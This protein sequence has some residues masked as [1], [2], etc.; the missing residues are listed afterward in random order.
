MLL[1]IDCAGVFF[2]GAHRQ[3]TATRS[4]GAQHY[5]GPRLPETISNHGKG[6]FLSTRQFTWTLGLLHNGSFHVSALLGATNFLLEVCC[7]FD[8]VLQYRLTLSFQFLRRGISRF[9]Q[10]S[11]GEFKILIVLKDYVV[12]RFVAEFINTFSSFVFSEYREL[13]VSDLAINKLF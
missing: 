9:I 4:Q 5:S 7:D 13:N 10:S 11:F 12:T 8:R 2:A 3:V 6:F 1:D